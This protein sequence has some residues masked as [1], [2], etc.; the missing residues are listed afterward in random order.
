MDVD[1]VVETNPVPPVETLLRAVD[2]RV[3][4]ALCV[5]MFVALL[6]VIAPAPFFPA[7]A[8]DL[9]VSVPLLGQIRAAMLLLS[10]VLGL[11]SGP[12]ADRYGHRRLIVLGLVSA[13]VSLVAFGLAPNFAVLLLGALAGGLAD[14]AVLGPS[15]AIAGTAFTGA[16]ARRALGWTTACMAGSAIVGVPI[17]AAVG[18]RAGW[19]AAFVVAGVV[20]VS[21]AWLGATWL[22]HDARHPEGRLRLRVIL[23]AYNPL[24][25]HGPTLRLYAVSVLR[26]ICFYGLLN[27]F[28]AFLSQKLGLTIGQIGIAYMLGGSGYFLGSL[29]AGG[30]LGRIP[31]RPLLVGGNVVMALL[32]GLALSAILGPIGTVAMLSVA[33]FA[34]AFGWVAIASLLTAETP[35]G[36]GTTMTLHGSLFN[37]GAAGGGAIGGAPARPPRLRRIGPR[38]AH[39]RPRVRAARRVAWAQ[40]RPRTT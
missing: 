9:G 22:P 39:L 14:A 19:R 15:L 7:M 30:P 10:A 28:G 13:A 6:P 32:M 23:D 20:A 24:L 38:L 26:A 36:A 40:N 17:L 25:H 3:L 31:P 11:V 21:T 35:A 18:D 33:T 2:R 27:Y 29:V 34:G 5:G 1:P 37:L 16:A 12:L 4:P 8:R